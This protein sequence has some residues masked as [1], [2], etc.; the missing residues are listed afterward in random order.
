MY[1]EEKI[2]DGLLWFRTSPTAEWE[3]KEGK[4]STAVAHLLRLTNDQRVGVFKR[5]C[6]HCGRP[7]PRCQCWNDE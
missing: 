7:D 3:L 5:F 6:T 2:S 1:Y 4:E